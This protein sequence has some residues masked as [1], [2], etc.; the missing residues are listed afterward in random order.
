MHA[1]GT[2]VRACQNDHHPRKSRCLAK[3][4]GLAADPEDTQVPLG[5]ELEQLALVDGTDTQLT[6]HGRNERRALG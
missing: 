4:T 3:Q 2:N 6:L 1:E 5:V